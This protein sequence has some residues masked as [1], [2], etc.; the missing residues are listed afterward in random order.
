MLMQL[1][2]VQFDV[3]PINTHEYD[4]AGSAS[5]AAHPVVGAMPP[6][7]AV[8]EGQESWTIRGKLFPHRF[9]GLAELDTLHA[10]R[11]AQQPQF[12][13]RGDGVPMG[14]VVIIRVQEKSSYLDREGVGRVIEFDVS[15]RRSQPP[16]AAGM[17][18]ALVSLF[19]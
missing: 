2:A 4:H 7:E 6:L 12:L 3:V 14:W 9:G 13:M 1:G 11:R 16:N 15:V 17:F 8:G 10:M 19:A 5:F 18:N